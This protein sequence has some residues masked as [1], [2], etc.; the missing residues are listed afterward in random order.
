MEPIIVK[1]STEFNTT[2][3]ELKDKFNEYQKNHQTEDAFHYSEASLAWIIRVGIDYFDQLD[4]VF[5]GMENKLGMPDMKADHFANNLY[6]LHNAMEFL[7]ELWKREY[8]ILDEFNILLDIRTLIVHSGEQLANIKSLELKDYKNS[9]LWRIASSKENNSI[10]HL[11]YFNNEGLAKMDYCLEIASDKHDK[12]KKSNLSI[13]DYHIQNESYRDQTIY[14]NAVDTRTI[15]LAQIEYFINCAAGQVKQDKS[16]PKLPPIKY[17]INKEDNEIDF[18]RIAKLVSKNL[19]GGYFIENGI[20][21]WD[22]F[23]LKKLLEYTKMRLDISPETRDLICE[24]IVNVMSKY[25]DD[26]QNADIP[27]EELPDLDIRKIFSD[28]TPDFDNKHYLE[29]EKLFIRIAPYFNT[30]DRKD[31]TD[32]GYLA[33][34]IDEISRALDI[35]FNLE[36]SVDGLVC[37]YII[38]SIKKKV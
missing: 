26:Y 1:P 16:D 19:R 37:D 14:L 4:N 25:W 13:V 3:E 12:S 17:F 22:G 9:Q 20:E 28:F 6:R 11:K 10:T 35:E 5:L 34:F 2:A 8:Q 38:E 23:G 30:K 36:Q 7:G 21:H 15:V 32:I 29:G 33:M 31:S 24:R 18:D 27:N